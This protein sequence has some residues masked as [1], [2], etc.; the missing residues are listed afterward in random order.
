MRNPPHSGQRSTR[1]TL[2]ARPAYSHRAGAFPELGVDPFGHPEE[3]VRKRCAV[4]GVYQ[5]EARVAI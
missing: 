2:K 5:N 3:A 1:K 4:G